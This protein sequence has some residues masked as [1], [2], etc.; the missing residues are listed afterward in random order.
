MFGGTVGE[1]ILDTAMGRQ[2]IGQTASKLG[3]EV[4][5][6]A[7]IAIATMG[8]GT[9]ARAAASGLTKVA[10]G[11]IQAG[12][13][14]GKVAAGTAKALNTVAGS[15]GTIK[16]TFGGNGVKGV[17][18]G[19]PTGAAAQIEPTSVAKPTQ[20][21]QVDAGIN[22][23]TTQAPELRPKAEIN[24]QGSGK[25]VGTQA[26]ALRPKAKISLLDKASASLNN[27]GKDHPLM[28]KAGTGAKKVAG[29]YGVQGA[30][31]LAS[32][33]QAAKQ[34]NAANQIQ[35]QSLLFQKQTYEEAKTKE[36]STKAQLKSDAWTAYSSASIFGDSLHGSDSNNTLL[37]SYNTNGTGNQGIY[38]ILNTGVTTKKLE[39]TL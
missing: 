33:N 38:S 35:T 32:I 14:V 12:T 23:N 26:P 39:D 8:V 3:K 25:V 22:L 16:G 24:M 21:V 7:P 20:T 37:T 34:S 31:S 17:A 29:Q 9:V 5:I 36:E 13:T 4:A 10:S 6:Q 27:F 1:S 11:A 2:S 19:V 30:L 15:L 28:A 18:K